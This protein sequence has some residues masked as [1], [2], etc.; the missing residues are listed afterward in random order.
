LRDYFSMR[1]PITFSAATSFTSITDN[2]NYPSTLPIYTFTSFDTTTS[3]SW[4]LRDLKLKEWW[5]GYLKKS[6]HWFRPYRNK[7]RQIHHQKTL[8]FLKEWAL[9][10]R[11]YKNASQI[12]CN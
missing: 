11:N 6:R 2:P 9:S 12:F 3:K 8:Q 5:K 4:S 7:W 1:V 10:M